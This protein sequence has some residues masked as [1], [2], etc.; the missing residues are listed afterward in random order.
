[1]ADMFVHL[2]GLRIMWDSMVCYEL[3]VCS[4]MCSSD[5]ENA[6]NVLLEPVQ[7]LVKQGSGGKVCC[8]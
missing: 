5:I 4:L 3:T 8:L 6:Q 7:K 1:M 2:S